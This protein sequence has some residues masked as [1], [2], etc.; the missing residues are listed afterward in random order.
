MEI[1]GIAMVLFGLI[2]ILLAAVGLVKMPNLYMRMQATSKATTLGTIV[3]LAGLCLVVPTT[4]MVW[5]SLAIV[6]FLLITTPVATHAIAK[7]YRL[8]KGKEGK[9]SKS[10]SESDS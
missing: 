7:E 9:A 4:E 5:K 10:Q 6:T 8:F 3:L 1:L 2:F